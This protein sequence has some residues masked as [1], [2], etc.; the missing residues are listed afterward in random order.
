MIFLLL[1]IN[2]SNII[3]KFENYIYIS[4]VIFYIIK[5]HRKSKFKKN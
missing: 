3:I 2:I 4:I 5:L 1:N